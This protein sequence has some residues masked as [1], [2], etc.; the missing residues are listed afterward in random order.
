HPAI[1]WS[2]KAPPRCEAQYD[3]ETPR[4]ATVYAVP[5][6]PPLYLPEDWEERVRAAGSI[7]FRASGDRAAT[8]ENLRLALAG[9]DGHGWAGAFALAQGQVAPFFGLGYGHLLLGTLAEAME[10]ENLLDVS[11]FWD[12]VQQAVALLAGFSFERSQESGD[13]SQEAGDSPG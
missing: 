6:S 1:L 5:E 2:A 11:A 3:H 13:R 12:D 10:H 4:P 8:L 7:T 9:A